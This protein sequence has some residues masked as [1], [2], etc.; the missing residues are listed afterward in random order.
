MRDVLLDAVRCRRSY[1]EYIRT[2]YATVALYNAKTGDNAES[3]ETARL[4][5][6][7]PQTTLA[8]VNWQEYYENFAPVEAIILDTADVRFS[9]FLR[10]RYSNISALNENYGADFESFDEVEPPWVAEDYA[11]FSERRGSLRRGY[12]SRNYVYVIKSVFLQGR[13]L[14]NT[15]ILVTL[16]V[17]AQITI[18]P[19]AAYALSRYRLTYSSKVL[20]FLL[21]TM[22][23]P[24]Q[25]TMIPNFL[26]I[27]DLGLLNTFGALV[28]PGLAN[29]YYIFLLKGFFD[30]LP[31]ELYEAAAIDGA[32]EVRM[33]WMITLPLSKP[34]LAVIA[35]FAFGTAYGSFLWAFTTC[36]DPKM[37][38]LM[39]FLHQFQ[40]ARA[41]APYL[42]MA[43]LVIAAIPTVIVFL[44]AQKVLMKGIVVPTMK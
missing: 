14:L 19:M 44:S 30:S 20:I 4:S 22:A 17:L 6:R 25:V 16:T 43:S 24:A 18:N 27:R 23:F 39:V 32:S 5:A 41:G 13:P 7:S 21:A 1:L 33:F 37:W 10:G 38:T 28:L 29:G 9:R 2:K 12:F 11:D 8:L 26:M 31:Q 3:L 15:F 35:L 34:V 42:V 36:Q 40:K